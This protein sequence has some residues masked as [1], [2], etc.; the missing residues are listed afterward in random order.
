MWTWL[1]RLF[2]GTEVAPECSASD[3]HVLMLKR[4]IQALKLE[5]EEREH[6]IGRLKADVERHRSGETQRVEA[7][8]GEGWERMVTDAATPLTQLMTQAH[9]LEVTGKPVQAADVLSVAK[10]LMRVFENEG[11]GWEGTVGATLLFDS[12]RHEPL[13]TDGDLVSGEPVMVR[14]VGVRYREQV[15]R[16]ARVERANS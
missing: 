14:F 9:L 5:L 6:L 12:D 8:V 1:R 7:V 16:K 10:R 2:C 3:K 13:G 15:L 11:V 4:E